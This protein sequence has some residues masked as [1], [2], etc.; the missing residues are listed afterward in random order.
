MIKINYVERIL[1]ENPQKI[2]TLI[3]LLTFLKK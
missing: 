1:M 3:K 2:M